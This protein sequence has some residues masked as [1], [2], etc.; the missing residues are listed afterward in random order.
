MAAG[1]V[2]CGSLSGVEAAHQAGTIVLAVINHRQMVEMVVGAVLWLKSAWN[3]AMVE[4]RWLR[5][6]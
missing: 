2:G 4:E 3:S 6:K 1:L 5:L